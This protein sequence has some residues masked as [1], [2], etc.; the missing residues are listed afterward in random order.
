MSDATKSMVELY[1][2]DATAKP[3]KRGQQIVAPS[4]RAADAD[5]VFAFGAWSW[6]RIRVRADRRQ[7]CAAV[8]RRAVL[9]G[10]RAAAEQGAAAGRRREA[11]A[12]FLR[13]ALVA[14]R[15]GG[16]RRSRS[17]PAKWAIQSN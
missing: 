12:L 15:G 5:R 11:D 4:R 17:L 2:G 6:E 9:H 10:R 8:R 1:V 7:R 3:E 13:E 16:L 14:E